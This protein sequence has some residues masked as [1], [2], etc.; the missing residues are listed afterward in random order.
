MPTPTM[1]LLPIRSSDQ[2]QPHRLHPTSE[3]IHFLHV[4][5][6]HHHTGLR[7]SKPGEDQIQHPIS[8]PSRNPRHLP[9]HTRPGPTGRTTRRRTRRHTAG[10][11]RVEVGD[12][13]GLIVLVQ[14]SYRKE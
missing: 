11:V 6:S 2:C 14:M 13:H 7:I 8:Q 5:A 4:G 10:C 3:P 12:R 1:N 9:N